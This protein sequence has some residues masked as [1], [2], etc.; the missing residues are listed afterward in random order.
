MMNLPFRALAL[1]LSLWTAGPALAG[2]QVITP[3]TP[4][5]SAAGSPA[6][7]AAP[8]DQ[9]GYDVI[10][11]LG[12][13]NSAGRGTYDATIDGT[14]MSRVYQFGGTPG[15]AYYQT[16][17]SGADPLQFPEAIETGLLGPGTTLARAY[18]ENISPNRRLLLVPLAWGGTA[19]ATTGTQNDAACGTTPCWSP[20]APGLLYT[21]AI[22]Q[23]NA[24]IA[25]AKAQ[26][27]ASRIVGMVW[28]QGEQDANTAQT[29]YAAALDALITGLRANIS[30]AQSA[31]FVVGS[32]LPEYIVGSSGSINAAHVDTPR[33]NAFT[34]FAPG[35]GPGFGNSDNLHYSAAGQRLASLSL[36]NGIIAAKANTVAGSAPAPVALPGQTLGLTAG[37]ASN[38]TLPL[39]W[40]APATGGAPTKYL[41]QYKLHSSSTWLNAGNTPGVSFSVLGLAFNSSYDFQVL[42]YNGSG[43][44]PASASITVTTPSY[45]PLAPALSA[46]SYVFEHEYVSGSTQDFK[47]ATNFAASGG[48]ALAGSQFGS[49]AGFVTGNTTSDYGTITGGTIGNIGSATAAKTTCVVAFKPLGTVTG[50]AAFLFGAGDGSTSQSTVPF[51]GIVSTAGTAVRVRDKSGTNTNV[52]TVASPVPTAG[53]AEVALAAL[54]VGASTSSVAASVNNGTSTAGTGT[55]PTNS[56]IATAFSRFDLGFAYGSSA[57]TNPANYAFAF[58][59][60]M[61][62]ESASDDAAVVNAFK[63]ALG[64]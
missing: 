10:L 16:I 28:V 59:A 27:P 50:T 2:P 43:F 54:T 45:A 51:T 34:A 5:G 6:S 19:L 33:R 48:A 41:V 63:M 30:G 47:G 25:A 13:S 7:T 24:A 38:T 9:S 3:P 60:C 17:I 35:P 57:S 23:A 4:V 58:D 18:A 1:A 55:P 22:A 20:T 32:M 8:W 61:Q 26:F 44:G 12:Q 31:W 15:T 29:T 36:F 64:L 39:S 49:K 21:N 56:I 11:L 42:A 37:T 53:T 14:P 40:S 52:A 46:G 62:G